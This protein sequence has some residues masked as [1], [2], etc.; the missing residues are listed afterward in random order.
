MQHTIVLGKGQVAH[1]GLPKADHGHMWRG[2]ILPILG[3]QL[4]TA[5]MS[6][7]Y[8]TCMHHVTCHTVRTTSTDHKSQAHS[9][10]FAPTTWVAQACTQ[11]RSG[12]P[13]AHALL[14]MVR[15]ASS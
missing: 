3:L 8:S 7:T 12:H 9:M 14:E 2:H 6:S 15:T 4:A 10:A 11:P 1:S 13:H 5:W